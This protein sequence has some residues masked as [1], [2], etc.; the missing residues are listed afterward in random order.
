MLSNIR[1][2]FTLWALV[3]TRQASEILVF[4]SRALVA[5]HMSEAARLNSWREAAFWALGADAVLAGGTHD[6]IGGAESTTTTLVALVAVE[7]GC[8]RLIFAFRT[9]SASVLS[10]FRIV[11]SSGAFPAETLALL[12]LPLSHRALLT[13]FV[14]LF[15]QVMTSVAADAQT[16]VRIRFAVVASRGSLSDIAE[17]AVV[18]VIEKSPIVSSRFAIYHILTGWCRSGIF[19]RH[20]GRVASEKLGRSTCGKQGS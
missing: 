9:L 20:V 17:Y 7:C 12:V 13:F 10:N 4:A 8:G 16:L 18:L 6:V 1:L 11:T 2:K 15:T 3:A 19:G 14:T 5:F